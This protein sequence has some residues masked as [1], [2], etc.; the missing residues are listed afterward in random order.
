[1]LVHK[2]FIKAA[3]DLVKKSEC[4]PIKVVAVKGE[5]LKEAIKARVKVLTG[6]DFSTLED[7]TLDALDELDCKVNEDPPAETPPEKEVDEKALIL[8][9]AEDVIDV[10]GY[11]KPAIQ[12]FKKMTDKKA[13]AEIQKM[14]N[15]INAPYEEN[16]KMITPDDT[17][18][19]FKPET[20]VFFTANAINVKWHEPERSDPITKKKKVPAK[21]K[22]KDKPAVKKKGPGVIATIQ[23]LVSKATKKKPVSKVD[24]LV[25]LEKAFPDRSSESMG[26]TIQAQ[27]P[28]RMAKEKGM[29]IVKN[30]KGD[31]YCE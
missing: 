11:E 9:A 2:D 15:E 4:M 26:K 5:A 8:A 17:P 29:A 10:L 3:K 27:L 13:V 1:M 24:L 30:E 6:F 18:E 16:G 12:K 22:D 21:A 19:L 23:T 14:A 28:K 31:F 7:A 20:L 25:E